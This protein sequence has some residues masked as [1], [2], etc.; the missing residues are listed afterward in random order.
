MTERSVEKR[1]RTRCRARTKAGHECRATAVEDG[2]CVI[3]SGRIDA[4]EIGAKGGRSRGKGKRGSFR[5][6]V[7]AVLERDPE[8]HAERLLDSG[9]AG[10]RLASELLEAEERAKAE[11]TP[12]GGLELDGVKVVG[13]ADLFAIAYRTGN[14]HLLGLPTTAAQ[15]AELVATEGAPPSGERRESQGLRTQRYGY[16]SAPPTSSSFRKSGRSRLAWRTR[17]RFE[18]SPRSPLGSRRT[19]TSTSSRRPTHAV[20][21]ALSLGS[22]LCRRHRHPGQGRSYSRTAKYA[23]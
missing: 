11:A 3:H 23:R 18:K 19:P 5:E 13:W 15:V 4:R 14:A 2:L 22:E 8:K 16:V 7:R 12:L 20:P 17:S 21:W 1:I 9:A 10:M 6:A